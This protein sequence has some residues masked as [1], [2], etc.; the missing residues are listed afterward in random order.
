MKGSS[1]PFP[2]KILNCSGLRQVFHSCS[3]FMTFFIVSR[4]EKGYKK[5]F[6]V[7]WAYN[8]FLIFLFCLVQPLSLLVE[9]VI[10]YL[11]YVIFLPEYCLNPVKLVQ[12]M[13]HPY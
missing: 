1:V 12:K 8:I 6:K 4:I 3:D 13:L 9:V 2:L 5:L 7:K 10:E 11:G